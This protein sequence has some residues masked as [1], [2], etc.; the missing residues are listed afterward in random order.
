M[1]N[2]FIFNHSD[3]LSYV[4]HA[5]TILHSPFI[6]CLVFHRKRQTVSLDIKVGMEGVGKRQKYCQVENGWGD[7]LESVPY[8]HYVSSNI[9]EKGEVICLWKK[10]DAL[11]GK[12]AW[13]L[14]GLMWTSSVTRHM[15]LRCGCSDI[16]YVTWEHCDMALKTKYQPFGFL[17]HS[18]PTPYPHFITSILTMF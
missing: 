12:Q 1:P 17:I 7:F 14:Q 3:I 10:D 5:Q 6:R 11:E 2:I 15:T 18:H 8:P 4:C 9:A 16:D 13:E